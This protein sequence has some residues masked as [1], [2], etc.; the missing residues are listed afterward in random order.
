VDNIECLNKIANMQTKIVKQ[1]QESRSTMHAK[2]C[3]IVGLQG[4]VSDIT[5]ECKRDIDDSK[6][7]LEM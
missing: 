3:V 1:I 5:E 2:D 7:M 6:A 4:E